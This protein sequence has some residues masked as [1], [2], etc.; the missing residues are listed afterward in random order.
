MKYF[1]Q[2]DVNCKNS[3]GKRLTSY[4]VTDPAKYYLCYN[5]EEYRH[6]DDTV[7]YSRYI[8]IFRGNGSSGSYSE[9]FA[10]TNNRSIYKDDFTIDTIVIDEYDSSELDDTQYYFKS[11]II[12][13][14]TD[15]EVLNH[16]VLA[17]I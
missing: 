16:L 8:A 11:D 17:S 15:E 3:N 12:F 7:S 9:L 5:I 14:L 6:C 13:E 2:Y 10:I 1:Y 4:V